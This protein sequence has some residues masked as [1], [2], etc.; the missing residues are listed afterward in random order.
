[1]SFKKVSIII[2]ALTIVVNSAS[3]KISPNKRYQHY[4]FI[5]SYGEEKLPIKVKDIVNNSLSPL[6]GVNYSYGYLYWE[7][8]L[9]VGYGVDVIPEKNDEWQQL[10][11]KDKEPKLYEAISLFDEQKKKTNLIKVFRSYMIPLDHSANDFYGCI[12]KKP[13][14][15]SPMIEGN[16]DALF[17][18]TGEGNHLY[19][20]QITDR[21][22]VNIFGDRLNWTF[23][24]ELFLANYY[25]EAGIDPKSGFDFSDIIN[26][27][28]D[29]PLLVKNDSRGRKKYAKMYIAD[30]NQDG[31]LEMLFWHRQY[32]STL[33]SDKD[34][35]GFTF[36]KQWFTY[37]V[38]QAATKLQPAKMVKAEISTELAQQL[39]KNNQLRWQDGYP[40]DNSLCKKVGVHAYPLMNYIIDDTIKTN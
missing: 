32:Q 3:A 24:E 14:F 29:Y 9:V 8:R 40:K 31:L 20:P 15:T 13:L 1:M 10:R 18:I 17:A 34:K 19:N 11:M 23:S 36:E 28:T 22:T 4:Q 35:V 33:I 37:Y 6:M 39:L 21:I 2:C 16:G 5:P 7:Q 12:D 27:K 38:E 26:F 30:L 25:N